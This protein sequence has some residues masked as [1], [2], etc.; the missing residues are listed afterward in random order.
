M[1]EQSFTVTGT[2][3]NHHRHTLHRP[4]SLGSRYGQSVV[5]IVSLCCS[6]RPLPVT[7]HYELP[8]DQDIRWNNKENSLELFTRNEIQPVTEIRTD[9]F[10]VL[11]NRILLQ[12]GPSPIQLIN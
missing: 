6:P 2:Y 4:S 11:E 5:G 1:C 7:P 10:F 9:I 12:M 8:H 3:R